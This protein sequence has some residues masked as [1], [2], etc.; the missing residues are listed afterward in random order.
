V[1]AERS[2]ANVEYLHGVVLLATFQ[3]GTRREVD[4]EGQLTGPVFEPLR[5]PAYF[6]LARFDPEIGTVVWPNGAGLAP[7]F[8]R[9]GPH[10]DHGCPCGHED[11]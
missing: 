2:L 11:S 8:L 6:A 10:L 5:D 3:D 7:E 1:T 4:M 9:W